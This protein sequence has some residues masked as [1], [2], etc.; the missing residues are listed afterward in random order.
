VG[1]L[2]A[3]LLDPSRLLDLPR[4]AQLLLAA[5]LYAVPFLFASLIFASSFQKTQDPAD[6]LASN[7]LGS[8]LGGA[9]ECLSFAT[10]LRALGFVALGLYL[11]AWLAGRRRT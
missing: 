3:T 11:L 9:L 6:A 7:L 2:A 4:V 10:G 1:L 8:V 5:P